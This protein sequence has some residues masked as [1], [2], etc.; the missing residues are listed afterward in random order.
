[1]GSIEKSNDLLKGD[2]DYQVAVIGAGP[3]GEDCARELAGAGLKVALVN[4]AP[5]PG[6]ECLWRGGI[7]PKTWGAGGARISDRQLGGDLGGAGTGPPR[8]GWGGVGGFWKTPRPGGGGWG[9]ATGLKYKK[10]DPHARARFTGEHELE[11]SEPGGENRRLSFGAAVIAT[12]APAFVPPIPGAHEGLACGAVLTSETIWDLAEQP[13]SLAIVGAGAIGLEMAQI[14]AHFGSRITLVEMMDRVLPDMEHAVALGL[15]NALLEEENLNLHC[16]AK[17]TKISGEPGNVSLSFLDSES[18]EHSVTVDR[19]LMAAGKRP[20]LDGLGLE[21]AGLETEDGLIRVDDSCRTNQPHIFAVGD[22]IGGLMLAHTASSQGRVAAENI[23]G[24]TARYDA[25][26]DGGVVFTR[27]QV[28]SVGLSLEQ[29]KDRGLDA[30]EFR[31]PLDV[32]V[33]ARLGFETHGMFKLVAE[34][35][36]GRILGAHLLADHADALIGEAVALVAGELTLDQLSRAIH[37][38]P[39][40]TEIWGE[41]AR[42]LKARFNRSCR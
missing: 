20:Q 24:K 9:A 41:M 26:L 11:L 13:E 3:G 29:A 33:K 17:V 8:F 22:V 15:Q 38:H 42:R 1:M 28:A 21:A 37:P 35:G 39:T 18:Q 2:W 27:P 31:Y 19:V 12:G 36:S 7:P 30:G 14:F 23:L 40:Q 32:D 4:D 5:L 6:G 10:A 25:D 16:G 34:K